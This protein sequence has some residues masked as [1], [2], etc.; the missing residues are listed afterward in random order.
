MAQKK[1][2]DYMQLMIMLSRPVT[3]VYTYAKTSCMI[4]KGQSELEAY[5]LCERKMIFFIM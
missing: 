2:D 1:W 3:Y 5:A 4:L